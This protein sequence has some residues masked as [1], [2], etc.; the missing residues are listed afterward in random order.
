MIFYIFLG[1]IKVHKKKNKKKKDLLQRRPQERL[2][3][4]QS[5]PWSES[6][7]GEMIDRL[8]PTVL[9][10]GGEV[11]GARE[12]EGLKAHL[13]VALDGARDGRKGIIG[14]GVEAA[15][16]VNGGEGVLAGDG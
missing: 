3:S 11:R 12:V 7:V 4:L 6:E 8:I 13:L 14:E 15:A 5:G 16:G 2:Q 10:A 1:F 9:V